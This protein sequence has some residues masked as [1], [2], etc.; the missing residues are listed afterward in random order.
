MADY[1][2][3]FP[4]INFFRFT[5]ENESLPANVFQ[6]PPDLLPYAN[7]YMYWQVVPKYYHLAMFSDRIEIMFH[8]QANDTYPTVINEPVCKLFRY[9]PDGDDD[10]ITTLVSQTQFFA[11]NT[12]PDGT[13]MYTTLVVGKWSDILDPTTD[14]GFYYLALYNYAADGVNYQRW[15]SEPIKVFDNR[16]ANIDTQYFIAS[17]NTNTKDVP[18][19]GWSPFG[20]GWT[21]KFYHRY[22]GFMSSYKPEG[23]EYAYLTQYYSQLTQNTGNWRTW[24]FKAGHRKGLPWWA[25][26]KITYMLQADN[27]YINYIQYLK[28]ANGNIGE[29]WR[30]DDTDTSALTSGEITLLDSS[31]SDSINSKRTSIT[32]LTMP[33]NAG[34]VSYPFLINALSLKVDGIAYTYEQD[35]PMF[36]S[37]HLDTYIANLNTWAGTQGLRGYFYAETY[38][39]K[40]SAAFGETPA[41]NLPG[42]S[43]WDYY[44]DTTFD[45]AVGHTTFGIVLSEITGGSTFDVVISWSA[46]TRGYQRFVASGPYTVNK[47]YA[48]YLNGRATIFTS[49][50]D[51]SGL[52][53]L[54]K[55]QYPAGG[56]NCYITSI[57]P[58]SRLPVA[59]ESL[60]LKTLVDNTWTSGYGTGSL[61]LDC[62]NTCDSTLQTLEIT[63]D[64][65]IGQFDNDIFGLG[66]YNFTALTRLVL[67][68]GLNVTNMNAVINNLNSEMSPPQYNGY[69]DC[70][71]FVYAA[72]PSGAAL[73][74]LNFLV[75]T[76]TWTVFHD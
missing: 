10:E 66:G 59:F 65:T 53:A 76:Y 18:I 46:N 1:C 67:K 20:G 32:V 70:R 36:N 37:G 41:T 49:G 45:V 4:K 58:S 60:K 31:N 39:I 11:N 75:S 64:P 23:Y 38:Y 30:L 61:N 35:M 13:P 55:I 47:S 50:T 54:G 63:D 56:N 57:L 34:A 9:N 73:S 29:L 44:F 21:V 62:I 16:S 3:Q 5:L 28:K 19:E 51:T 14:S 17:Y 52:R 24:K 2:A 7:S 15:L 25:F 72:P 22:E 26:E 6:S 68:V 27:V 8:T 12:Y 69:L 74:Y 40:Y 71:N 43:L 42:N 48:G 33:D